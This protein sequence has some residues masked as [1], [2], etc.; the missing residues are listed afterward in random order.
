MR[1]GGNGGRKRK[2]EHSVFVMEMNWSLTPCQSF[3][4]FGT[5]SHFIFLLDSLKIKCYP[6]ILI[7]LLRLDLFT[8]VATLK[9]NHDPTELTLNYR[10]LD[11]T[12]A[13]RRAVFFIFSLFN[14]LSSMKNTKRKKKK[15]PTLLMFLNATRPRLRRKQG[16]CFRIGVKKRPNLMRVETWT[17]KHLKEKQKCD[18]RQSDLLKCCSL[19]SNNSK[20]LYVQCLHTKDSRAFV[21]KHNF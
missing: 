3:P 4:S 5:E 18:C 10:G 1:Y 19:E 13:S 8:S 2:T 6:L 15:H 14:L 16:L 12:H 7:L 11:K 17:G 20:H 21:R 9:W